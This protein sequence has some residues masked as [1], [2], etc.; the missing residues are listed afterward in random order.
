T[1]TPKPTWVEG[2]YG[3]A[4]N[5]DGSQN[6]LLA[7]SS[8]SV[9]NVTIE[10]WVYPTATLTSAK[11]AVFEVQADYGLRFTGSK[12]AMA[13]TTVNN[14]FNQLGLSN[15]TINPNHWYFVAA[16]YD[17]TT[18]TYYLNGL[19]D[20]TKT[21]DSGNMSSTSGRNF[22]I[23][24]DTNSTFFPGIIDDVKVY[25]Y[26]RTQAQIAYDY[27]RGAPVGWWKMDECQ[28]TTLN[29]SSGNNN[30]GTI[31]IG[32]S[33]TQTSAGTCNTSG[34][35]WGN[36]VIGKFNSSLNFDGTD[37]YISITNPSSDDFGTG[38][39]SISA[40]IKT[41]DTTDFQSIVDNKF[42]G[43][44]NAG[45]D[46]QLNTTPLGGKPFFRTANGTSQSSTNQSAPPNVADGQWHHLV[47]T[48][49]R[50][51]SSD[52][53]SLYVDGKLITSSSVT[54]GW[55]ISSSQNL[56]IGAY[57]TALGNS[58]FGGQIDDV[59]IY[60]YALSLTQVQK[61]YN[62]GFSTFYGP[63]TGTP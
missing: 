48:L 44:N 4:L 34:T 56:Y 47:G 27:N 61:L 20:G 52:T 55:N 7:A 58:N 28:G 24:R 18:V 26:A 53:I 10:G 51:I 2:K 22:Y 54:A 50:G 30:A 60:N 49:T 45:F 11:G 9:T 33:G 12:L 59:R 6:Y 42:Q 32:A 15:T 57:S 31:N 43:T 8:P 40:W 1:G 46:L 13:L 29:D 17:G 63:S 37:D 62:D 23:G 36:G 14:T 25:N 3:K 5:F 41:T 21:T 38:P 39:M 35:A 19:Q 16:T